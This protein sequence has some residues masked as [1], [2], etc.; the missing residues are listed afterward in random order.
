VNF[1]NSRGFREAR[2]EDFG[3]GEKRLFASEVRCAFVGLGFD[4]FDFLSN[5]IQHLQSHQIRQGQGQGDFTA[6]Y[7]LDMS[8]SAR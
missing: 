7:D 4:G 2:N 8:F 5:A 6:P 3:E 1:E